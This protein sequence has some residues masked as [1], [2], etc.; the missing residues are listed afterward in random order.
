MDIRAAIADLTAHRDLSAADM[1]AVVRAI[2][3]GEA[4]HAQT[5]AL[6]VALRMKGE[7][8]EEIVGAAR[9]MRRHATPVPVAGDV[10]D[11]CGTGGDLRGT[12][13]ISTAAALIAAGAGLRIAKHGNR[14]MS[15]AV[16]GA[17]VLEALGVRLDLDAARVAA[18]I[19][20][21]G[22]G[23]LFAQA[24]HPAM[25]HVAPIRREIG[26]RTLFNLLGP[27]TNPAGAKRQVLGVFGREW[28]EPLAHALG[29]LGSQRALVVHGEDGL[30]ELSLTGPSWVAELRDGRVHT[31][32]FTPAEA[33][34]TPCGPEDLRGGDAAHNAAILRAIVENRAS[35]AQR[36]I[37][38]LNAGAALY[39][40]GAAARIA[41]GVE[42]AR[43]ALD[44][45]AAARTLD[46]LIEFTS[47]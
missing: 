9:A 38:L 5:A 6:L 46:A 24:F 40:A 16:G 4:T 33:G 22:V 37:A 15:G 42:L 44:N 47:R 25:K 45:G 20:T 41:A 26:V 28:V 13:N 3:A 11:T 19:E 27:L 17:D 1:E 29:G 31:S 14:A 12:F 18:C 21:V 43:T 35:A 2:M 30:D 34:L 8:V 32:R 36:D 39:V 7:R 10:L 23:F